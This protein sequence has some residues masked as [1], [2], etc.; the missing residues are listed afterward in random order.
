MAQNSPISGNIDPKAFPFLVAD[1]HK[2]SATGSLKI[3]G[4]SYQKALYFRGGRVLFGSSNDPRDQLGAILIENGKITTE[5]LDDVSSKVGPGNPLAKVLSE[6][7]FVSQRELQEAARLKVE[8]ILTD[9]LN[10]HAG[11]FEFEDGVLP[12]G[13]VDLKLATEALI[14]AAVRQVSDRAF[15]LRHLDSM[16]ACLAPASSPP[17][18]SSL[19]PETKGLLKQL[20]GS[21]S[22]REAAERAG[23]DEFEAG[24]LACALLFLGLV[25]KGQGEGAGARRDEPE[26]HLEEDDTE[27]DL[28]Q[29]ARQAF[30]PDIE[31]T[32]MDRPSPVPPPPPPAAAPAPFPPTVAMPPPAAPV[33]AP[34]PP[35]RIDEAVTAIK[36]PAAAGPRLP[37]LVPPPPRPRPPGSTTGAVK[38]PSR[39]DLAAL[40]A[41]LEPRP[42]EGP[43]E[44]FDRGRHAAENRH[45]AEGLPSFEPPREEA[46]PGRWRL[47]A[48]GAALVTSLAIAVWAWFPGILTGFATPPA[49]SPSAGPAASPTAAV[50]PTPLP[51][52]SPVLS[53]DSAPSSP[54]PGPVATPTPPPPAPDDLATARTMLQLR[55]FD[56]AAQGFL[57]HLRQAPAGTATIQI[58]LA[59][60]ADTVGKAV[61]NAGA[62]ELM[63]V[64]VRYQGKDCYRVLW[65]IFSGS[66]DASA[67][68]GGVPDYFRRE[69][70]RPRAVSAASVLP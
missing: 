52:P 13:A 50:P 8:R 10:Y 1:L 12:K 7:G 28:G 51:I 47:L 29:T 55:R 27:L 56:E 6:T 18:E 49:A 67:A 2:S 57:A 11:S 36:P 62:P 9:V 43:L 25:R 4:P 66:G 20:D 39:D 5:Q 68:L 15:V 48:L 69:G 64:P 45:A 21:R 54:A 61:A 34:A 46:G 30:V 41:L 59:C 38:R 3:D 19:T 23:L 44:T 70:A 24:K 58:L 40:D 42:S 22:V 14:A 32:I 17:P 37:P 53:P 33:S 31:P 63:V 16:D 35:P 60:Q 65:G 26:L